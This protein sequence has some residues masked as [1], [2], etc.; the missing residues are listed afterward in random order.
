MELEAGKYYR[1]LADNKVECIWNNENYAVCVHNGIPFAYNIDGRIYEKDAC[2]AGEWHDLPEGFKPWF[3]GECPPSGRVTILAD[4]GGKRMM[5]PAGSEEMDWTCSK[6]IGYKVIED[7][8]EGKQ[9]GRK[10]LDDGNYAYEITWYDNAPATVEYK[11]QKISLY[12]IFSYKQYKHCLHEDR[13]HN[14]THV[15]MAD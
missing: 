13:K 2:I 10:K 3:G 5:F 12:K 15:V 7:K 4:F 14:A 9:R 6:I 11:G 8:P 1:T